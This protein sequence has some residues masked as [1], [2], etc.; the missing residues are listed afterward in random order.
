MRAEYTRGQQQQ[1]YPAF[2]AVFRSSGS[3]TAL[4]R[5]SARKIFGGL[6][7]GVCGLSRIGFKASKVSGT[8]SNPRGSHRA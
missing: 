5:H 3:G 4:R 7:L 1:Q 6:G 2:V 8:G